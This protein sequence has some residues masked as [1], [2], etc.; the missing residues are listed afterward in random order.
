VQKLAHRWQIHKNDAKKYI[1]PFYTVTLSA[2][3]VAFDWRRWQHK[4]RRFDV[5]C[6]YFR[7]RD[8]RPRSLRPTSG[9]NRICGRGDSVVVVSLR[10]PRMPN[11]SRRWCY[12]S[13]R[14]RRPGITQVI[15]VRTGSRVQVRLEAIRRRR[16]RISTRRNSTSGFVT[17]VVNVTDI[18]DS[19]SDGIT[20]HYD[21]RES[22]DYREWLVGDLAARQ[23]LCMSCRSPAKRLIGQRC[24][25]IDRRENLLPRD[26]TPASRNGT[27]RTH[28]SNNALNDTEWAW[29]T[30]LEP[31][32][33]LFVA[34]YIRTGSG[35]R[36]HPFANTTRR[37]CVVCSFLRFWSPQIFLLAYLLI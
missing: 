26:S 34:K 18:R 20:S 23:C 19:Y 24:W 25:L 27:R 1:L 22:I 8:R 37:R 13:S 28:S 29:R 21:T 5:I 31:D 32:G 11:R 12:S 4:W 14:L 35:L 3:R 33:Q 6:R 15:S 17:S 16:R 30:G 36:K 7:P 10:I 9:L 2:V